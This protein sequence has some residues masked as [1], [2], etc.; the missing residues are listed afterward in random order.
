MGDVL[1]GALYGAVVI[2]GVAAL[3]IGGPYAAVVVA[4]AIA[5]FVEA[6]W[7]NVEAGIA[8][9]VM[10]WLLVVGALVGAVAGGAP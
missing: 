8:A 6:R 5:D 10:F 4:S 7:G 3:A 1:A 9:A 2:G